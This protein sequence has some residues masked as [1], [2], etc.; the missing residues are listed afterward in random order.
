MLNYMKLISMVG[1]LIA[2]TNVLAEQGKVGFGFD[3]GLGVAGQFN[4]VNGFLG[5]DGLGADYLLQEGRFDREFPFNWYLG[6]GAYYGWKD[7]DE[8]GA[9]VPFGLSY[10]FADHWEL[11]AQLSPAMEYDFA[12]DE[13]GFVVGAGLGI[14]YAFQ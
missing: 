9:R 10:P 13:F 1:L 12:K 11:F 3:H 2:S 8:I 14:R 5:N 7:H 6:V 4:G